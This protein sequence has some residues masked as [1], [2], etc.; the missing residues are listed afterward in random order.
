MKNRLNTSLMS[1][2]VISLLAFS[3]CGQ[4]DTTDYC[5][6]GTLSNAVSDAT[7]AGQRAALAANFDTNTS[8]YSQSPRDID[9]PIGDHNTSVS[10]APSR[11]LNLCDIHF[12]K[13]AEHRGGAFSKYAG[14]GNGEGYGSGYKYRGT[15]T[16]AE[17]TTYDISDTHNPLHA[18]DTIEV[19]YVYS[20]SPVATLGHGLG[21]CL[22]SD[23]SAPVL[24]VEARVFV[25][26]NDGN[27]L[28]FTTLNNITAT[29]FVNNGNQVE[30]INSGNYFNLLNHVQYQGSTTGPDYNEVVSP[31]SVTWDVSPEVGKLNISTVDTWLQS[32]DFNETHAHGVRNLV[33]NPHLLSQIGGNG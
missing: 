26:T 9:M 7:I 6:T 32:N 14:N 21:T 19:H 17:L 29:G 8:A 27:G 23:G 2:A 20:N 31:Y 24:R 5:P 4:D 1:L 11:F 22:N 3:G 15:L 25:L 28:D 10:A 13:N 16:D 33:I 12:H 18:G 30:V